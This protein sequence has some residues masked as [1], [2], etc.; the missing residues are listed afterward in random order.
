MADIRNVAG[1]LGIELRGVGASLEALCS[2]SGPKIIHL[3]GPDHFLLLVR[4]SAEWVQ[5]LDSGRVIVVPREEIEKRYSGHALVLQQTEADAGGPKLQLEE[6]HYPFGIVGVGQ[7]VEHAFAIRNVGDEDLVIGLPGQGCGTL[8][9]SMGKTALAPGEST[10]LK[11]KFAVGYSG[12]LMRSAKLVTNDLAQPVVFVTIHGK[13]P[14]D[15]RAHPDR[16]DLIGGKADT[17]SSAVTV[18]GPAEMDLGEIRCKGSLLDVQVGAPQIGED[19]RK[20]WR[21]TVSLKPG[22]V[23]GEFAD[24]LSIRTTHKDR[25]LI[26]IPIRGTVRPDLT[27]TPPSAFFGFARKGAQATAAMEVRSRSGAPFK[28]LKVTA[29]DPAIQVSQ[30]RTDGGY[31]LDISVPTDKLG[32]LEGELTLTTDVPL[33]ET[34]RVPVYVHVVE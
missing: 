8:P 32:V 15:L 22:T 18:S 33:E 1:S 19:E 27:L 3:R 29:G 28:L 10:E 4:A 6:F 5:L 31:R 14:H 2:V 34:V 7:T 25:P 11:A 26:T 20:T 23:V 16:L 24:E 9:V 13:V 12:N 21:L 30:S 17:T